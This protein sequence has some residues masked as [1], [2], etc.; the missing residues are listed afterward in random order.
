MLKVLKACPCVIQDNKI[1]AFK[2]P[3]AGFQIPKG[4]VEDHESI[5]EAV[6]RE[7]AEES[8]ITAASIGSKVGELDWIIEAGTHSFLQ[9]EHQEWHIFLVKP[10]HP[11]PAQWHHTAEGSEAEEGLNFEFFWQSFDSIPEQFHPV[12]REVINMVASHL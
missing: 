12:Y 11:L 2:H 5:E 6:L 7:L 4:S 3:S 1:L 9:A 10:E 8:G